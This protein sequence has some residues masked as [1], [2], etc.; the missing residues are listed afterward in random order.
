M[1]SQA[2]VIS[3][4]VLCTLE[5]HTI[6]LVVAPVAPPGITGNNNGCY[7]RFNTKPFRIRYRVG[8]MTRPS[9]TLAPPPRS[10]WVGPEFVFSLK[11]VSCMSLYVGS[12]STLV[13]R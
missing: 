9:K 11:W 6:L 2:L 12:P 5:C 1:S 13:E 10:L 3:N 8:R 4:C 7:G